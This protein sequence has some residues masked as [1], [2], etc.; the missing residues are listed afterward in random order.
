MDNFD[1]IFTQDFELLNQEIT[2]V[3]KNQT[4]DYYFLNLANL[5]IVEKDQV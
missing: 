3:T 2:L 5:M 1:Q 4:V